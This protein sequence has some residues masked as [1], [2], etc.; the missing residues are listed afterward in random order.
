VDKSVDCS[1]I[2]TAP[3]DKIYVC[4]LAYYMGDVYSL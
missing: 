4:T 1:R 3:E 2:S